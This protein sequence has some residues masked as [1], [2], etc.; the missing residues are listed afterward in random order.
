M[1]W[2]NKQIRDATAAGRVGD[3]NNDAKIM[4]GKQLRVALADAPSYTL[5][6]KILS[7][8]EKMVKDENAGCWDWKTGLRA[9]LIRR[10]CC[11][12]W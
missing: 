7:E 8:V 12:F 1:T 5:T 4:S 3:G 10:I 9:R 2:K 6:L 11:M